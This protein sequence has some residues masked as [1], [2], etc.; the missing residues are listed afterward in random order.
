MSLDVD[1]DHLVAT[2]TRRGE[3]VATAE[4]ITAGL[5]VARLVDVPGASAVVR[6]GLVA[7]ATEVKVD[8]AGLDADLID[9]VGTVHPSIAI[10]LAR[11]A[12]RMT[13][14]TFG[15]GTTGVAGPGKHEGHPAGTV[16]VAAVRGVDDERPVTTSHR[17][18][19]DRTRVR[20]EATRAAL[21]ALGARLGP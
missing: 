2:L 3:T 21:S 19:G 15:V 6:G 18:A 7:Y 11:A 10:E 4:S 9:Q 12:A 1:L 17:F 5:V 16:H 14:A 8:L 20:D 13:G